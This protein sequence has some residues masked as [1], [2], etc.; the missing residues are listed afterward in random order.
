METDHHESARAVVLHAQTSG[1]SRRT[2]RCS[3]RSAPH[4]VERVGQR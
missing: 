4:R 1:T 3:G 2:T